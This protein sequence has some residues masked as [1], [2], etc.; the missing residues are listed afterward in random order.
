M[1]YVNYIKLNT[2]RKEL[3]HADPIKAKIVDIAN[4]WG[5]W[6]MGQFATDYKRLFG[7][8]PKETIAG[9]NK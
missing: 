7:E 6:H 8:L 2:I 5:F 1:R 4:N 9:I 3:K